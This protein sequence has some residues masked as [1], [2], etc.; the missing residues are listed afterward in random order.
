MCYVLDRPEYA[1]MCQIVD[2]YTYLDRYAKSQ[3]VLLQNAGNDEFFLPSDTWFYWDEMK[4]SKF[5]KIY[6]NKGH[7]GV[8]LRESVTME[9]PEI[10]NI[11]W[12][13]INGVFE[14][15]LAPT[16]LA[17]STLHSKVTIWVIQI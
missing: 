14:Q 2:P 15:V 1:Q 17:K 12:N 5:M 8:G 13:T 11:V 4:G 3:T 9:T 6:E 16:I 7:G 10:G